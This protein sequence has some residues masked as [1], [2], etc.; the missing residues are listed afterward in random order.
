MGR[1]IGANIDNFAH[2]VTHLLFV[3]DCFI[4]T[5]ATLPEVKI[6]L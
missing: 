3:D 1:L 4:V 6:E 5:R 2:L